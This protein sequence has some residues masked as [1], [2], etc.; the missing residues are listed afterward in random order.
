MAGERTLPPVNVRLRGGSARALA[1]A[2]RARRDHARDK[3]KV[4]GYAGHE[5]GGVELA[6]LSIKNGGSLNISLTRGH[7]EVYGLKL[8]DGTAVR[9]RGALAR[10]RAPLVE[11]RAEPCWPFFLRACRAR[12]VSSPR[13]V[14]LDRVRWPRAVMTRSITV[15][16]DI[17]LR[18]DRPLASRV[19]LL[20]RQRRRRV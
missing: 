2:R 19:R 1:L 4:T 3:L 6:G 18:V 12:G 17:D 5:R 14:A 13:F 16:D 9:E 8:A 20:H 11:T 7:V 10:S 15:V